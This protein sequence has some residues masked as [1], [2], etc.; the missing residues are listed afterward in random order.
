MGEH[1][2]VDA[3]DDPVTVDRIAA[4]LRDLGAEA[5]DTLLVHSALSELGWV[6]GGSQAVVDAL[7]RVVNDAGTVVMPTHSTQYNDPSVWSNP[8]VPD[9]WI[10]RIR[11]SMPPFR[12]AVTTT[13]SMG[14]IPECFRNYPGAVRSRHPLYSFAAWGADAE[15]VVDDHG[16]ENG[17]GEDSPLAR[18][19]ER[20]GCVLLLGTGHETN[21]SLHLAEYR[22]DTDADRTTVGAPVLRDG[23]REWVE[24][25]SIEHDSGDFPEI[26]AAFEAEHPDAVAEG[27][28]GAATAKLIDQSTLVGFGVEWMNEHR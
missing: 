17:M 12:P 23:E 13:R 3:V 1:A 14:A 4:D 5:G 10:E 28:V 7:R 26:G 19:Y 20:D 6:A 22:A 8:P 18:V 16:F 24:W 9:D 25:E 2:A 27:A 11:E 21:T 15:T